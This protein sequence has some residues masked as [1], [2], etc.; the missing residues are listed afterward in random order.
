MGIGIGIGLA[1]LVAG[2][3]VRV[4]SQPGTFRIARSI[5]VKAPA[6]VLFE[7][8]NDFHRWPA[9]S[10][11]VAMDPSMKTSFSGPTAGV[12]SVYEWNGNNKVGAG[13]MTIRESA[14]DTRVGMELLLFRP[15]AANNQ[16][17]FTFQPEGS[18]VR[19]T[20]ST[21]GS[22][23]LLGKAF[24]LVVDVDRLVGKDF[25]KGLLS[26]KQ[27]AETHSSSLPAAT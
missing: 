2:L 13:K 26:L 20:W 8:V 6:R 11:Y 9:W 4:V 23:N 12:G 19:V 15:M 14:P 17:E 5:T 1:L 22:N 27:Q 3:A 16:A 25:E 18:D 10:P 7:Q 24:S 21:S